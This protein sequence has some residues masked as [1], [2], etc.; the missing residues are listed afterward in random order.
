MLVAVAA[1]GDTTP[2]VSQHSTVLGSQS[3]RP[4]AAHDVHEKADASMHR[5]PVSLN[6]R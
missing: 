5:S 2:A 4:P 1:S 3:K 6:T